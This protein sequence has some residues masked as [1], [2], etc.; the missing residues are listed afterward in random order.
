MMHK[1]KLSL[2]SII[3]AALF[4]IGIINYFG[5]TESVNGGSHLG[6]IILICSL[7]AGSIIGSAGYAFRA[8]NKLNKENQ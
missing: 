4:I 1:I 7:L 5:V 2:W 6:T 3:I 8:I